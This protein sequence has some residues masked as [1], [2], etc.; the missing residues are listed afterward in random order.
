MLYDM[1][2]GIELSSAEIR[3]DMHQHTAGQDKH[4]PRKAMLQRQTTD[5][6]SASDT[7]LDV[8]EVRPDAA[9]SSRQQSPDERKKQFKLAKGWS[10]VALQDQ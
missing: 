2:E 8:E 3:M 9:G 1:Q 7:A 5:D 4:K 10:D 6:F